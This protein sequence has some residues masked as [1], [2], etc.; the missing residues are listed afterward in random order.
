MK[1]ITS[2]Q[3]IN[4]D[5]SQSSRD[6]QTKST[7]KPTRLITHVPRKTTT[8]R[9]SAPLPHTAPNALTRSGEQRSLH[10]LHPQPA[11]HSATRSALASRLSLNNSLEL[12]VQRYGI[13]TNSTV[14][15]SGSVYCQRFI[16]TEKVLAWTEIPQAWGGEGGGDGFPMMIFH[17]RQRQTVTDLDEARVGESH[18]QI[19][20]AAL[21]TTQSTA[22]KKKKKKK[23]RKKG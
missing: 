5:T 3:L 15:S 13:V 21:D 22:K 6:S 9:D 16:V 18:T 4:I 20:R 17:V 2:W 1:N 19:W 8:R 23:E 7:Q 14:T 10:V 11:T 12:N